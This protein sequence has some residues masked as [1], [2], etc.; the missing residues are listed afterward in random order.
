MNDIELRATPEHRKRLSKLISTDGSE[1]QHPD[2]WA[3]ILD[4]VTPYL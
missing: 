1:Y 3:T 2:L 4:A